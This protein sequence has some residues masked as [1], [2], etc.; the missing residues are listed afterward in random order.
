M[1]RTFIEKFTVTHTPQLVTHDLSSPGP[2]MNPQWIQ[3]NLNT[4]INV[5][6]ALKISCILAQLS[7]GFLTKNPGPYGMLETGASLTKNKLN[8]ATSGEVRWPCYKT[9]SDCQ[10]LGSTEKQR[11]RRGPVDLDKCFKPKLC[12]LGCARDHVLYC[13]VGRHAA[14][15]IGALIYH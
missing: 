4:R 15:C 3:Q 12:L 5:Y 14:A 8:R 7:H 6:K 10:W 1:L 9:T 2:T 13:L 11:Q